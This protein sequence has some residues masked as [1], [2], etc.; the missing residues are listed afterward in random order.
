MPHDGEYGLTQKRF[1]AV[2]G[3]IFTG[4]NSVA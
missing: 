3:P 1:G 4:S 2:F